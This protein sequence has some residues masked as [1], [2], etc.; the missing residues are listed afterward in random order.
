MVSAEN[1]WVELCLP[2]RNDLPDAFCL[3]LPV[4]TVI[5]CSARERHQFQPLAIVLSI[6]LDSLLKTGIHYREICAQVIES[7]Q[8][9]R[10]KTIEA[11]C[12][13]LAELCIVCFGQ[14]QVSVTVEKLKC[15]NSA[16]IH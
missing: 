1:V 16:R 2:K 9:A 13:S 8:A 6:P 3:R 7:T 4:S 10:F 15:L 14:S 5:G 12:A 11:L